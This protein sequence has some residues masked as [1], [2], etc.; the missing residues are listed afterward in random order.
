MKKSAPAHGV[1]PSASDLRHLAFCALCALE[2]SRQDGKISNAHSETLFMVRWLSTAQKQKRFPKSVA[3]EITLMLD[4][5]RR[6]GT[7]ANLCNHLETLWNMN[8]HSIARGSGLFR[9]TQAIQAMKNLGWEN[10]TVSEEE[11]VQQDNAGIEANGFIVEKA[12]LHEAFDCH[13]RLTE[14]LEIHVI[15]KASIFEQQLNEHKFP[16]KKSAKSGNLTL[17]TIYPP[18]VRSCE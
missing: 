15:G 14:S 8:N 2:F 17:V 11:W 5:G 18:Q 9:L 16:N 13:G 10:Y 7:D 6:Y 12:A 3:S 1:T 4:R